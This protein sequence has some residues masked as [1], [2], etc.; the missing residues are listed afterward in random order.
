VKKK[1]KLMKEKAVTMGTKTATKNDNS[2]LN[3][4]KG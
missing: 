1:E 4:E 2:K 3:E